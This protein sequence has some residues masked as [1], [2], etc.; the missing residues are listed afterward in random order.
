MKAPSLF[1]GKQLFVGSTL[2]DPK[3]PITSLLVGP[4]A[5]RGSMYCAGPALYGSSLSFIAPEA[6]MMIARCLNPETAGAVP[7]VL[8]VTSRLNVPTPIDVVLGDIEGPVGVT[9][10]TLVWNH[11]NDTFINIL[12][13]KTFHTGILYTTGLRMA[14]GAEIRKAVKAEIGLQS[15]TGGEVQNGVQVTN[16][17]EKSGPAVKPVMACKIIKGTCTGNKVKFDIPHATKKGKRIRHLI[18]EGPEAGIYIRGRMSETSVINLP[19]Y[20]NGLVD[21]ESI[22]VTLTPY[23]RPQNL[24]V[25]SIPYGRQVIVKAEDGS[26]PNCHYQIWAARWINGYDHDEELHVV[27]DGETADDYPGDNEIFSYLSEDVRY[28]HVSNDEIKDVLTSEEGE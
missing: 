1:V 12:T 7:S 20:W 2:P 9:N 14:T 13:P 10:H 23:G 8:K 27:Y 16:G 6:T 19:E 22:T 5:I 11:I 17:V 3:G 4:A 25:D 15:K 24:Y 28:E 18:A 21:P 26:Q